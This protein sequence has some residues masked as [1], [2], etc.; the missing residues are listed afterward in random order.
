[1]ADA[2]CG[3]VHQHGLALKR[4]RL[5]QEGLQRVRFAVPEFHHELPGGEQRHGGCGGM[6]VIDAGRLPRKFRRRH[7]DIFRIGLA[8]PDAEEAHHGIDLVA[9]G[10]AL[11]I[12]GDR[13][14]NT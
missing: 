14:D 13:L 5:M 7:G 4:D 12:L 6:N 9:G 8:F 11:D 10:K 3:P 1:M 2:A